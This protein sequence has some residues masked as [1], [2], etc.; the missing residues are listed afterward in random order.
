MNTAI[1]LSHRFGLAL[2]HCLDRVLAQSWLLELLAA[3]GTAW[4]TVDAEPS[5]RRFT[6][7]RRPLA[8]RS[9]SAMPPRQ[10]NLPC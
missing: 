5:R 6:R 2:D 7:V 1:K 4:P 9:T 10:E 3:A 8:S